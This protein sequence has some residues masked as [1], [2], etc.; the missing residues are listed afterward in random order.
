[1]IEAQRAQEL[2]RATILKAELEKKGQMSQIDDLTV[3]V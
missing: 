3:W 2:A 1:M